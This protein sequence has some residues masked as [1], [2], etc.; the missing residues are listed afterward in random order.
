LQPLLD[1]LKSG[2]NIPAGDGF[3]PNQ[4]GWDCYMKEPLDLPVL[5]RLIERDP[6]RDKIEL[7]QDAVICQHCWS[8][9]HGPARH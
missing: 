3:Q 9:I 6:Y 8:G 7:T 1:A 5:A 2:G 4:G